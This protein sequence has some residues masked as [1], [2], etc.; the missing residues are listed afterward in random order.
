MRFFAVILL[1]LQP[2]VAAV[3]SSGQAARLVIGQTTFTSQE[4]GTNQT[5]VG[6]VGGLAWANGSLFVVDSN[7]V[8]A[9]PVNNRVLIFQDLPSILPGPTDELPQTR[10]CPVCFGGATLVLGQ[11][12][13]TTADVEIPPTQTSFR[14][15]TAVATDGEILAVADTDNNRVLIWKSIPTGSQT[16]P[17]IVL[18]QKNFTSGE[19]AVPPNASS[20]RGPQGVWIQDGKLF[21]ADTLNNRVLIWNTIPDSNGA[22]ADF[23]LGQPGFNVLPD[24]D[25]VTALQRVSATTLYTPVSVSSDGQRMYVADLA[26]DRVLI[27]NSIPTSSGQPADVAIGQPDMNSYGANNVTKMCEAAGTDDE[28]NLLYPARCGGTLDT[29]RFVLSDGQRLYIA[30]TGND[31]VLVFNSI[32]AV[33]GQSADV[34]LGQQ[35]LLSN[36][37]SDVDELHIASADSLRGPLGLA[38]DGANLYVSDP[39]NRRILV[40]TPAEPSIPYTGVRNSASRSVHAVGTLSFM[41]AIQKDDKV[42]VTIGENEYSYTLAADD[43]M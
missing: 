35:T 41:G 4:S 18:G 14:I 31:R 5:L 27:W 21:V 37:S 24:A 33:N 17:D 23:V 8:A 22:P 30:D 42:T 34:V 26:Y 43:T 7:R 39:Y 32:P 15:P 40:F 29:P 38:W 36:Q 3:F 25:P 16:P 10:R 2:A 9:D 13:F 11:P 20:L 1:A 6:G 12:D 19:A 28:G